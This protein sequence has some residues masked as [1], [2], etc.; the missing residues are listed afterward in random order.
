MSK[1][2]SEE[3]KIAGRTKADVSAVAAMFYHQAQSL[4]VAVLNFVEKFDVS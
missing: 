1:T 2:Y 3:Q 4:C